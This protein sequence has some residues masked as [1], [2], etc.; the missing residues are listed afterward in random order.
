MNVI[1]TGTT[2]MIGE[3]VLLECLASPAVDHVL[4]LN[5][6]SLGRQHAKLVEVLHKDF[7]DFSPL[8]A[9]I[10]DFAPDA[11]YHCMGVSSVGMDEESYS[12]LT[13][14]VTKS[15][16]DTV[17]A[18]TPGAVFTYVSGAGSDE[19]ESGNTMWARVKGKTENYVLNRGFKDAYAFRIGAVIP[20]KGVKSSTGWVNLLY[21]V[22]RPI[23]GLMKHSSS[24][25]TSSQLGQSMIAVSKKPVA[26]KR[27][28][29]KDIAATVA[30]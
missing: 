19:T 2:G 10:N 6:N 29:S 5:R 30:G 9:T 14:D 13:F 21:I 28:E 26:E 11:C 8:Q 16:A 15:L 17:Y 25:I 4:I 23:F 7:T 22:I 3:S 12:R 27:L 24:V 1:I 18:A 20:E